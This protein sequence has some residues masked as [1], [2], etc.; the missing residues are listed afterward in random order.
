MRKTDA[1][2][3]PQPWSPKAVLAVR[4]GLLD[5]VPKPERRKRSR[6]HVYARGQIEQADN[7]RAVKTVK[8]SCAHTVAVATYEVDGQFLSLASPFGHYKAVVGLQNPHRLA[9]RLLRNVCIRA[10][11]GASPA[12]EMIDLGV[13][14]PVET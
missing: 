6:F 8:C 12:K 9:Q 14:M 4:T 11:D 5:P 10:N 7:E 1:P 2:T 13:P 3:G